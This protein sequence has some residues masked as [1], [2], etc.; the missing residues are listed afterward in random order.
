MANLQHTFI[1]ANPAERKPVDEITDRAKRY[2]AQ[3]AVTGPKKCV[4][5][6][7]RPNR[8]DV[9]HL[10]GDESNGEPQNLAYGCRSCNAKLAYAFKNMG[11]GVPTRQYN[12][13]KKGVPTYKQYLWGV[14]HHAPGAHDEGGAIIHGTPRSKRIEYAGRIAAFKA[15]RRGEVPF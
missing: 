7:T 14:T 1:I 8:I 4:I 9:M 2:R 12:P 11:A 3:K 6:G 5:C 15:G 10:D 13:A